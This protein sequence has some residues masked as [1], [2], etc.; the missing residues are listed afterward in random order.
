M[1]C[2]HVN[3]LFS[4]YIDGALDAT[5]RRRV[6]EH[7]AACESC[8]EDLRALQAG[9]SALQS[10]GR[11]LAPA[12]FLDRVNERIE[13]D[14]RRSLFRWLKEKLLFPLH[15]KIPLE[16]AG[17]AAA[18]LL[19]VF[20][21]HG[22][23]QGAELSG[24]QGRGPEPS[25]APARIEA[26][27]AGKSERKSE[28]SS[29]ERP[30]PT[31]AQLPPPAPPAPGKVRMNE[32]TPSPAPASVAA[33]AAAPAPVSKPTSKPTSV[34][35]ARQLQLV[36][37]IPQAKGAT[38]GLAESNGRAE[39]SDRPKEAR[40]STSAFKLKKKAASEP[41][42]A[43]K[44]SPEAPSVARGSAMPYQMQTDGTLH[45]RQAT[46][47]ALSD[48]DE[49]SAQPAPSLGAMRHLPAGSKPT[50]VPASP[51][52]KASDPWKV[53]AE[54]KGFVQTA[55]GTVESVQYSDVTS[56]PQDLMARLPARSLEQFLDH[57]RRIGQ[58]RNPA[59]IRSLASG[60]ETLTVHIHFELAQARQ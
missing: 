31:P 13:L 33:Q 34:E 10:L 47:D 46:K 52:T 55:G 37:L 4:D 8:A 30:E 9:I 59:E 22:A 51:E 12:D 3:E 19:V 32:A 42:P 53:L 56:Q 39:E 28:T 35:G 5:T 48:I 29:Q 38:T 50:D 27:V 60:V 2:S 41:P 14:T 15:V 57:L 43:G 21:Y 18:A 45:D 44:V 40:D 24:G 23:Q 58:L 25:Y 20:I 49:K 1:E 17:L 16:A 36:L 11:I 6:E 7:L 54:I 26:P